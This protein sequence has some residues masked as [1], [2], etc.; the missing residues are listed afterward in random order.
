VE[1]GGCD[2][3]ERIQRTVHSQGHIGENV[4]KKKSQTKNLSP[5]FSN[6]F[7]MVGDMVQNDYIQL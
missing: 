1:K 2:W 5:L 3:T 7:A 6:L 4:E